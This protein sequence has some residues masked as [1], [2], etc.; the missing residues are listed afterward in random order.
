MNDIT[1]SYPG[2]GPDVTRRNKR[3]IIYLLSVTPAPDISGDSDPD[4]SIR[5]VFTPGDD[6]SHIEAKENGV[7]NDTGL[8]L[9]PGSLEVGRDLFIGAAASFVR[10]TNPSIID[11]HSEALLPHIPFDDDGTGFPHTPITDKLT[12]DVIFSGAVSEVSGTIIG[13]VFVSTISRMIKTI[14]HEVGTVGASAPITYS[15]YVGTDNTGFLVERELIPTADAAA[16]TT[17]TIP[18]NFEQGL[19]ANTTYFIELVSDNSF[20]LKT[21]VGSNIL[22]TIDEEELSDLDLVTENLVLNN[23]L[24]H[25][26][27]NSLNP[28]YSNPFPIF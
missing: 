11:G 3:S 20:T 8:R 26:W 5:W 24:D 22:M 17:L 25:V 6:V 2:G 16:N 21:D 15:I 19:R 14:F 10:T 9:G 7:Y 23:D 12:T 4:G 28:V 18:F 27:D 13:Q 1:V